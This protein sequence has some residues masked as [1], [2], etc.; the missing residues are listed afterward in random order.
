M[1]H[2]EAELTYS[3]HT[4]VYQLF[5]GSIH[6]L[7][8]HLAPTASPCQSPRPC[9]AAP[10]QR[11]FTRE[12]SHC[13]GYSVTCLPAGWTGQLVLAGQRGQSGFSRAS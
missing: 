7:T 1:P 9:S 6:L 11:C 8:S 12:L 5:F 13:G 10:I 3:R 4:G 2:S